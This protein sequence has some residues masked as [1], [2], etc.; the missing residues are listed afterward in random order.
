MV[1]IKQPVDYFVTRVIT[2]AKTEGIGQ[3]DKF[4]HIYCHYMEKVHNCGMSVSLAV[5]RF[6][7]DLAG[8]NY[9]P[10]KPQRSGFGNTKQEA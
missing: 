5:D 10:S 2:R 7:R 3:D 9:H 8:D 4:N 6:F 1:K